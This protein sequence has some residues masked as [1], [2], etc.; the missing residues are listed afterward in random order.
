MVILPGNPFS[1]TDIGARQQIHDQRFII[2]RRIDYRFDQA[3]LLGRDPLGFKFPLWETGF[4]QSQ[5]NIRTGFSLI[6]D[7]EFARIRILSDNRAFDGM[8]LRKPHEFFE[9]FRTNSHRHTFLRFGNPDLPLIKA[10]V[11]Q[12]HFFKLDFTAV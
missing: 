11:F 4:Q 7:M 1:G 10:R 6:G 8:F 2:I 12:R 5:I 9:I 3:A